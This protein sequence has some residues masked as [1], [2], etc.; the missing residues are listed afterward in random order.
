MDTTD[1]DRSASFLDLYLI[2]DSE[3]RLTTKLYFF[4]IVNFQAICSNI[5]RTLAYVVYISQLIIP[6]S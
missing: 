4:F 3:G 1:T 5:R 6:Y 2:T